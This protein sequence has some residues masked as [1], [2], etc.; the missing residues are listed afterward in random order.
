ML[1]PAAEP[2]RGNGRRNQPWKKVFMALSQ[3]AGPV[4]PGHWYT[5]HPVIHAPAPLALRFWARHRDG[6]SKDYLSDRLRRRLI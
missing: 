4:G 2:A 6:W 3:R 5:R 1:A